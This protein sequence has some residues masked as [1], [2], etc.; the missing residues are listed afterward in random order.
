MECQT[1]IAYVSNERFRAVAGALL[2]FHR[3]DASAGVARSSASGAVYADIEPGEYAVTIAA[4]GYGSTRTTAQIGGKTPWQFRLLSDSIYGYAWPKWVKSGQ[5]SQFRVH[6]HEPYHLSLW[7]YGNEKELVENIGWFD[8][9]G[10]KPNLQVLPDGDFS[11]TGVKW[12]QRGYRTGIQ[13]VVAP[14]RSGLYYF[15]AKARPSG[16]TFGFP[17]VVAPAKPTARIAV[18]AS[19]NTWNAYNNFGGRSNYINSTGLPPTPTVNARLDLGRYQDEDAYSVWR[20]RNDAY[21]PLSFDRPEPFNDIPTNVKSTDPIRGRQACHLAETEWRLLAWMER[22]GFEYDLYSEQQLHAGELDLDAYRVFVLSTH[23]EYWSLQAYDRVFRW[24]HERGGRL[25]YLG[26]NGIDCEVEFLDGGN[27]MRCKTWQP[28]P[29]GSIVTTDPDTGRAYD[30]RFHL[31]TGR[32][33]AEL[34]GVVFSETGNATSAPFRAVDASPWA[35]AGTNLRDGEIFGTI[36]LHERCPHGASGHETD[37]RTPNSPANAHILAR[38]MNADNGGAEMVYFETASGGAVFSAGSIT[39]PACVA[40]DP[41]V[42]R[43]TRNVLE[44][45]L[46]G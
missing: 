44:R 13:Q 20:P 5:T 17:W 40:I 24:V 19:T 43:I 34:L 9:H 25:M 11:Q 30:C 31:S 46:T 18:L 28:R 15:H 36:S 35:F 33:P 26:G 27:A 3:G 4:R 41:H 10:P 38:G 21:A 12:N 7:R 22:Q 1:P 32:S 42:S 37:K 45:F 39:W 6:A 2:E 8:E 29:P 16:R 23:P 14:A